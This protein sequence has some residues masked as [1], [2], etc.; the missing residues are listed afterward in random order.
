MLP[1]FYG[2]FILHF[3]FNFNILIDL[4]GQILDES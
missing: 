1:N 3:I 4:F 2:D